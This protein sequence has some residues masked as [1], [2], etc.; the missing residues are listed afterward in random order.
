MSDLSSK[1]RES[2]KEKLKLQFELEKVKHEVDALVTSSQ[3]Q[4]PTSP[5]ASTGESGDE[6]DSSLAPNG[7]GDRGSGLLDRN[8]E[9]LHELEK[10]Y[11]E[12]QSMVCD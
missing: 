9:K 10:E 4:S 7:S 5:D 6:L 11:L 8:V 2:E 3:S 12:T 1:L